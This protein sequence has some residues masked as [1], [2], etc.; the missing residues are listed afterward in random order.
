VFDADDL[1]ATQ[2]YWSDAVVSAVV[3]WPDLIDLL[4]L[5]GVGMH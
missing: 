4:T 2:S 5:D 3:L 1:D